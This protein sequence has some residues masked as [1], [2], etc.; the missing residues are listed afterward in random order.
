M[1][2][3]RLHVEGACGGLEL[4]LVDAV[5]KSLRAQIEVAIP[6]HRLF[7]GRLAA[8]VGAQC[9]LVLANDA[10][11]EA[12]ACGSVIVGECLARFGKQVRLFDLER[13]QVHHRQHA[14][15]RRTRAMA[16]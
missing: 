10:R 3:A 8:K 11:H 13:L 14:I 16:G 12:C 6:G 15:H 4:G 5:L 2:V 7:F 1:K 9:V